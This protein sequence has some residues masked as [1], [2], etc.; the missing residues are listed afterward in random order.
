[1]ERSGT[2]TD[3]RSILGIFVLLTLFSTNSLALKLSVTDRQSFSTEQNQKLDQ[4]ITVLDQVLNSAEFREA[5]LNFSHNG[6]PGFVNNNGLSNLEI[7]HQLMDAAEKFP[8]Q[9]P[10]DQ[11]ADMKLSIYF[12]PFWKPYSRA[13]AFTSPSDPWLHIYNRYYNDAKISDIANTVIHEWTHK[14]GFDHDFNPTPDRPYSVPYGIGGII[15]KLAAQYV[16]Q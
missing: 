14:M 15:K 13:V 11:V 2:D 9:H 5:V 3:M 6:V 4:A 1:M 16:G 12:P 8:V 7:Y 10:A